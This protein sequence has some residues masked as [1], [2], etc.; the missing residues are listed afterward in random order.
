MGM[1]LRNALV[2][3]SMPENREY[4]WPLSSAKSARSEHLDKAIHEL[5]AVFG[6]FGHKS[7]SAAS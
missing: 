5:V 6:R 4:Y 3:T 1:V 7:R 2:K